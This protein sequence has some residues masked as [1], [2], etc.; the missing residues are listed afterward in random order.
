MGGGAYMQERWPLKKVKCILLEYIL[1]PKCFYGIF[2]L[3]KII[4][5]P[6]ANEV[7]GKVIFSEACVSHS[8]HKC[9]RWRGR[10]ACMVGGRVHG[11]GNV[12][13]GNTWWI[14]CM[15]G[16]MHGGGHTWWGCMVGSIRGGGHAWWE[17]HGGGNAWW[18]ECMVEGMHGG[19]HA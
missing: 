2:Q 4:Y 18:L 6:P 3:P 14:A 13:W 15:V 16:S 1:I 9:W 5:L 19:E 12:W 10:G 8:V 17:V 7:W 11:G